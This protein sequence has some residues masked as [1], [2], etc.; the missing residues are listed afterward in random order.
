M[1]KEAIQKLVLRQDLTEKEAIEVMTEIMSGQTTESQIAGYITALRMK[2][3]TVDEITASAKVMR[4][5]CIPVRTQSS[6][7]DIARDDINIDRETI[8]DTCGTGGDNTKT[9]NISTATAFVVA[10]AGIPVA[11]HGNRS[12]SSVCGSADVIE[13]LGVKLDLTQEKAQECLSKCGIVFLFAPIWHGSMKYALG[14]RRQLGIRTIFNILGPLCNP[15]NTTAQVLGVYSTELVEILAKV[16]Q[17][18]GLKHAFVVHGVDSLDEISITGDTKVAELVNKGIKNYTITPE[19]F[20]I[21]RAELKDIKGGDVKQNAEIILKI[22]SGEKGPKRDI[23]LMNASV[24][25]MAADKITDFKDGIN[26][27]EKSIDSGA[28]MKKLTLIK[29]FTSK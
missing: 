16:L 12:V 24:A 1:I 25:L 8:L 22:L 20:G 29:E 28:A 4:Q 19:Q 13:S 6:S 21:K 15:A 7:V 10:G 2:G 18:L 3:E 11:K 14:P 5:F 27:A 23:V 26:L 17:N 9:F